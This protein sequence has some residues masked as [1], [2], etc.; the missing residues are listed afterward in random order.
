MPTSV[1]HA[2]PPPLLD[3]FALAKDND[4]NVERQFLEASAGT[5]LQAEALSTMSQ[6]IL[7]SGKVTKNMHLG[8]LGD[9]LVNGKLENVHAWARNKAGSGNP[10][11]WLKEKIGWAYSWHERRML[12]EGYFVNGQEFLYGALNIG[13][14]GAT[15]YGNVSIVIDDVFLQNSPVTY[16]EGDSLEL[17]LDSNDQLILPTLKK[18]ISSQTQRH[19]LM[20]FKHRFRLDGTPQEDWP[21]MVCSKNEFVEVIFLQPLE[22]SHI[23]RVLIDAEFYNRLQDQLE[24]INFQLQEE[25]PPELATYVQVIEVLKK[26]NIRLETLS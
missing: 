3:L 20:A 16:L 2:S 21:K 11:D 19:H 13:S 14:L 1:S 26:Y 5:S 10:L 24:A 8:V 23:T 25:V 4:N 9:L 18:S 6:Q 12:F 17:F 15:H 22:R 7:Y